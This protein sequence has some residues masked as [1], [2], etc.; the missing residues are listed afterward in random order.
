MSIMRYTRKTRTSNNLSPFLL[1]MTPP[2]LS[3]G[4]EVLQLDGQTVHLLLQLLIGPHQPPLI[5]GAAIHLVFHGAELPLQ[6]IHAAPETAHFGLELLGPPH[7]V[8]ELRGLLLEHFLQLAV[9]VL[10]FGEFAALLE[11]LVRRV[12]C[13]GALCKSGLVKRSLFLGILNQIRRW[14]DV[15]KTAS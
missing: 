12:R 11:Y 5:G 7:G 10:Q 15:G 6:L 9:S 3:P 1:I 8:G 13:Y 14:S 4:L 2:P